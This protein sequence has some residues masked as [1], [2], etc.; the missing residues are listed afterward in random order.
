[1]N[2]LFLLIVLIL[3]TQY[4]LLAQETEVT[5]VGGLITITDI[6]GAASND[7]LTL[8]YAAGTYTLTDG[9]GL[10][11]TTTIAGGTGDGTASITFPETGVTDITFNLLACP[12]LAATEMMSPYH[13]QQS[14]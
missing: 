4:H 10:T 6:N 1:M 8:E 14:K 5:L 2:R 3:G 9:G 11:I 12:M 7:D 13:I